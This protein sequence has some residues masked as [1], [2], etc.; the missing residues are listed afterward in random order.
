MSDSNTTAFHRPTRPTALILVAQRNPHPG[1]RL[2]QESV[3]E[4][5][6]RMEAQPS[7]CSSICGVRQRL[8]QCVKRALRLNLG[9]V[10]PNIF[11]TILSEAEFLDNSCPL[12]HLRGNIENDNP[13]TPTY[14]LLGRPLCNVSG[15]VFKETLT[16]KSSAWMQVKQRLRPIWKPLL[17]K[18]V[19]S[20]NIRPK[21]TSL[22]AAL[23]VKDV[24]WLLENFTKK[25]YLAAWT[26]HANFHQ[27]PILLGHAK[28]VL[29]NFIRPVV[30]LAYVYKQV[31]VRFS[32]P[33][34]Y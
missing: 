22:E 14:F 2:H 24:V 26:R 5:F 23:E 30:K 3:T 21:W 29:G 15:V 18:I 19:P 11:A 1:P 6:C 16:L 25:R 12:T 7:F 8:V 31:R 32:G 9:S 10:K 34:G 4:L 33:R 13:L 20:L 28:I 27:P 17:T